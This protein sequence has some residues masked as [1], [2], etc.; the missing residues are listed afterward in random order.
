MSWLT[1]RTQQQGRWLVLTGTFRETQAPD[2]LSLQDNSPA[3]RSAVE[4]DVMLAIWMV[5]CPEQ[6]WHPS[7]QLGIHLSG[8][9]SVRRLSEW[10]FGWGQQRALGI[11]MGMVA[12]GVC[13]RLSVGS[14][15]SQLGVGRAVL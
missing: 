4:A 10:V 8:K 5:A 9:Q 1:G 7:G 6:S 15:R 11:N 12:T 13:R 14:P 2:L 3:R